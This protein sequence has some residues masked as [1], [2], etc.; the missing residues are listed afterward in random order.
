MEEEKD[1]HT[2]IQNH[3]TGQRMQPLSNACLLALFY[4]LSTCPIHPSGLLPA[5]Q[6]TV[7]N[8]WLNTKW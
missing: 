4:L 5:R 7:N 8:M 1:R 6:D 2:Q 3:N